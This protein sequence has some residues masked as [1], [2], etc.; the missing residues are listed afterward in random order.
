MKF[1]HREGEVKQNEAFGVREE[2]KGKGR[3]L[4]P[5]PHLSR[6]LLKQLL[7]PQLQGNAGGLQGG[8]SLVLAKRV[9]TPTP[10]CPL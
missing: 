4:R 7:Q 8:G 10:S 5:P 6:Q 2:S 9:S 1:K 3:M